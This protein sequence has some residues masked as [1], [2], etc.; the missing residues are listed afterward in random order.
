MSSVEYIWNIGILSLILSLL[1]FA[2]SLMASVR[3]SDTNIALDI[4]KLRNIGII[5]AIIFLIISASR[6][7]YAML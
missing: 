6:I 7:L 4:K 1:S 3:N 2:M 5:S